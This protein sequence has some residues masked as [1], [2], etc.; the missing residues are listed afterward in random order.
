MGEDTSEEVFHDEVEIEDFQYDEE[1]ESFTYPC[2][3]GDLFTIT[4]EDLENGEEVATCPSC[5]L[6]VK[7]I[8]NPE[9][10]DDLIRCKVKEK[11]SPSTVSHGDKTTV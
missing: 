4:K 8:Y 9:D 10:I 7:V 5:S 11:K 2:P 3:C 6:V 1:T